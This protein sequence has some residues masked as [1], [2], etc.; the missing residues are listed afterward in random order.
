MVESPVAHRFEV[1]SADKADAEALVKLTLEFLRE[2]RIP[3]DRARVRRAYEGCL[4]R[5]KDFPTFLL[6]SGN[7]PVGYAL[8]FLRPSTQH[9]TVMRV[10]DLYVEPCVRNLG[11]GHRLVEH[12]VEYARRAGATKLEM[13]LSDANLD[14]RRL[15]GRLGFRP[16]GRC[17]SSLEL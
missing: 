8:S 15:F 6:L 11:A 14:A 3:P 9:G 10:H 13:E 7:Q 5:P 4:A 12:L 17:I 1:R 16:A 2:M